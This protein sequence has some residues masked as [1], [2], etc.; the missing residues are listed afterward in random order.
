VDPQRKYRT[1]I[2]LF[3][4]C[5][6]AVVFLLSAV[7]QG[8]QTLRRL[9]VVEFE[10]DL[11][12]KPSEIIQAL[13][14]NDGSIVGDLGSG[15]GYFSLKLTGTVG[16]QGKVF[17]VDIRR[18]PLLFLWIRAFLTNQHNIRAIHADPDNPHLPAGVMDA[19]LVV[20]TYHELTHPQLILASLHRSL[21]PG[22]R[23][24]IVD[25][26]PASSGQETRKIEAKHHEL[27]LFLVEQDL[28]Q[29]GFEVVDRKV[30]FTEE[31]GHGPWWLLVA[32]KP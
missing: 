10:R 28:R 18:L 12:Q 29:E 13:N 23:L 32:R 9:E 22:G 31:P 3:L 20:N 25:R 2:G 1:R 14:L 27:P 21:V 26:G 24:V 8:I 5:V 17:A 11:W 7:Y 19:V 30:P 4:G 15:A 16:K 6:V